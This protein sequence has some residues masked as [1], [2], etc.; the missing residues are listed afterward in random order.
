MSVSIEVIVQYCQELLQPSRF[1]D[2][3]PNG[4]QVAGKERISKIVSGVTACQQ[5]LDAAVEA[6]A[7]LVLVHHG[8]FWKGEEQTVVSIKKQRLK[9]L[10]INDLNLLAYHLPLDAHSVFG[11]NVQLAEKMGWCITSGMD[12]EIGQ[13]L[14]LLGELEQACTAT[15]LAAH[16]G[17]VLNREPLH[18]KGHDRLIKK[19]AWCTGSAQSYIDA[20]S[21]TDVDAFISGEISEQTVHLARELGIDYYAAGHHAT[22]SYGVQALGEHI[23]REFAIEHQFIDIYNP[24]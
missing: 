20:V 7:D 5:L 17:I 16:I 8:Y 21:K 18:V 9:T 19:I 23:A 12:A 24:V 22:E 3:C 11:N 13:S 2:Y 10:L 1:Q 4:L 6:K 14:V 15:E